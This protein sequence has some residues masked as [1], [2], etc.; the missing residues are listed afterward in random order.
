MVTAKTGSVRRLLRYEGAVLR[1]LLR[2]TVV[3]WRDGLFLAI[4]LFVVLLSLKAALE[5]VPADRRM[6]VAAA[7]AALLSAMVERALSRQLAMHSTQTHLAAEALNAVTAWRYRLAGHGLALALAGAVVAA[8]APALTP[9]VLAGWLVGGSTAWLVLDLLSGVAGGER[10]GAARTP[11]ALRWRRS[12][13]RLGQSLLLLGPVVA[14]LAHVVPFEEAASAAGVI[15]M[16]HVALF[17]PLDH[18][19]IDFERIAGY[20][21]SQSLKRNLLR[22]L[23]AAGVLASAALL[24][25]DPFYMLSVLLPGLAVLLYRVL[26]LMVFRIFPPRPAEFVLLCSLWA[27]AVIG[28]MLPVLLPVVLVVFLLLAGRR[29]S[30]RSWI[31]P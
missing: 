25:L 1:G 26:Q 15:A 14:V 4:F 28:L 31:M 16:I 22:G 24:S 18:A 23:I 2:Q 13:R 20:G 21:V 5:A 19:T 29:A 6:L 10:R 9:F 3:N 27:I 17:S 11:M 7:A 8:F 30:A 12:R